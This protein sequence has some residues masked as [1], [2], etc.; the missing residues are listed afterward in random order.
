MT[1]FPGSPKLLKGG[2]VLMDPGR[3]WSSASSQC[4]ATRNRSGARCRSRGGGGRRRSVRSGPV[5]GAAGGDDQVGRGDRCHRSVGVSRAESDDDAVGDP[6]P[7]R[8]VG[9]DI[10]P[11]SARL[12]ANN[13]LANRVRRNRAHGDAPHA[14]RLGKNW[15]LPVRITD[16]SV[17]EKPSISSSILSGPR[18]A[19]ACVC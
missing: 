18:S 19:S 8:G 14:L 17:T 4:N 2:M 5:Q 12:L 9:N 1:T 7:N 13:T 6:S 10:Y 11:S 16:L 3:R 15:I